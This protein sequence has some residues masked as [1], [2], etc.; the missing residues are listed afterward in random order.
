V[1]RI[2]QAALEAVQQAGLSPERIDALYFTG[3]STGLRFLVD[4]LQAAFAQA[5]A[6]QG[7][8]LAS[9]ATGLGLYA[10]RCFAA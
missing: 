4:A 7:D 9:V 2:V 8:R 6:V 10:E 1:G 3:G 5:K